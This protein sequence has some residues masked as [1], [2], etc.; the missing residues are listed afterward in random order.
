MLNLNDSSDKNLAWMAAVGK[1][2]MTTQFVDN[3]EGLSSRKGGKFN[4]VSLGC[5]VH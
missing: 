3:S 1:L 2:K 4:Q 5:V